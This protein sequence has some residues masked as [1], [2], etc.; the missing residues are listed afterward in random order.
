MTSGVAAVDAARMRSR[1]LVGGIATAALALPL[2]SCGS[3]K[4]GYCDDKE[5]LKSSI[6]SLPN[7][8][9]SGGVSALQSS[10]KKIQSDAKSLVSSAKSDFPSET[11]AIS[12]SVNS[13]QSSVQGL[14]SSP[15][16]QSLAGLLPQAQSA[17]NSVTAFDQASKS[18]CD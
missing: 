8:V 15:S 17:V 1:T 3:S 16:A 10:L 12:S 11:Q 6:Q 9:Q 5:S 14:G 4:P 18:K 7:E 2:A 13:L